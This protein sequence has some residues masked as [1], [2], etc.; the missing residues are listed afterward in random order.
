[1]AAI[2]RRENDLA[3]L[4][5]SLDRR[6]I[7]SGVSLDRRGITSRRDEGTTYGE[8]SAVAEIQFGTDAPMPAGRAP[9]SALGLGDR[10]GGYERP[11]MFRLPDE[12]LQ[13]VRAFLAADDRP[14]WLELP[15]PC[16]YLRLV[17]WETLL[18]AT[19][20]RPVLRL[21]YFSLLPQAA[22]DTLEVAV[23]A[24]SPRAKAAFDVTDALIR[25]VEIVGR[26]LDRKWRVHVFADVD[27]YHHLEQEWQDRAHIVVH[28]PNNAES[29][30]LPERAP[31]IGIGANIRN[32]WLLWILKELGGRAVDVVHFICHGYFADDRGAIALA[33]SP[34]VNTDATYSRFVGAPELGGFLTAAG[35][36]SIG[37]TGPDN[38]FAPLGLREVA[39]SLAQ[40]RPLHVLAHEAGEDPQFAEIEAAYRLMFT[41]LPRPAPLLRAS[42]LWVHPNLVAGARSPAPPELTGD[43]WLDEQGSTALLGP[44][45]KRVLHGE[46]TPAWVAAS[47]RVIEQV[48]GDL[49]GP[50][51]TTRSQLLERASPED[52]EQALRS[53]ANLL[54]QHVVADSPRGTIR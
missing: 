53:A 22:R 14:L 31:K 48:Q 12:L 50:L 18:T 4:R 3:V 28:N 16:G 1:M 41:T 49:L 40:T 27:Q 11:E 26:T 45:T 47:A 44:E 25:Y 38:N 6:G 30:E 52:V 20:D 15:E 35:A 8:S 17:P 37:L 42:A 19:L 46:L 10:V 51:G 43:Q 23:C 34:L 7:T 2:L 54:E 21:P 39:D 32:P 36:W 33:S 13:A 29:F 24:S 5:V 9:V